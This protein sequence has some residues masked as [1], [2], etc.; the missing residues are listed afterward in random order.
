MLLKIDKLR[1][2]ANIWNGKVTGNNKSELDNIINEFDICIESCNIIWLDRN[3][4]GGRVVYYVKNNISHET[5]SCISNDIEHI[6][7]EPLSQEK[8]Q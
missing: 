5:K 6:F 3:R 2:I 7:I 1:K 4:K 8:P